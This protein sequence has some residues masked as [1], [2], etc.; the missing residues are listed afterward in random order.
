MTQTVQVQSP[1]AVL[2]APEQHQPGTYWTVH[3]WA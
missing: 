2:S 3:W 1:Y